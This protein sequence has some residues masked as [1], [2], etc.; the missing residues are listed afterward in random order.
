MLWFKQTEGVKTSKDAR[1]A[2]ETSYTEA[3]V[4]SAGKKVGEW[5]DPH[6]AVQFRSDLGIVKYIG[7]MGFDVSKDAEDWMAN[8]KGRI[9]D[10]GYP[11]G[12]IKGAFAGI[13]ATYADYG[14]FYIGGPPVQGR[15]RM[16]MS[17]G[18][19]NAMAVVRG[20]GGNCLESSLLIA[21]TLSKLGFRAAVFTSRVHI[22]PGVLSDKPDADGMTAFQVGLDL[23]F[24]PI[25]LNFLR[26]DPYAVDRQIHF[27]Y[28][29]VSDLYYP[30]Y[31]EELATTPVKSEKVAGG[32]LV[33]ID[34]KII[35]ADRDHLDIHPPLF[36]A[37]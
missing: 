30:T 33:D 28:R 19:R 11:E 21:T 24:Y 2:S 4:V 36:M 8:V 15:E 10:A 9:A 27:G 3:A 20:R 23:Y 35:W 14:I 29:F 25:D 32:L 34:G 37:R 7:M 18:V 17:R 12:S 6:P 16:D 13:T 1:S 26:G 31:T 5:D 22:V